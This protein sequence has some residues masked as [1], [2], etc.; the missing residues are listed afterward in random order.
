M[1]V[2]ALELGTDSETNL[3]Q[4]ESSCLQVTAEDHG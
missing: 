4:L 2:A 3:G 1:P